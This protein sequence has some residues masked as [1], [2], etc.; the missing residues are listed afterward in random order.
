VR[1]ARREGIDRGGFRPGGEKFFIQ[2][3]RE[4][5]APMPQAHL[6]KMTAGE[7]MKSLPVV[8]GKLAVHIIPVNG[9]LSKRKNDE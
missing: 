8:R 6:P 1:R 5:D 2:Q 9:G 4:G 7:R 3:R